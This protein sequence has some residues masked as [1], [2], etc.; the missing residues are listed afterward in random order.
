MRQLEAKILEINKVIGAALPL[1]NLHGLSELLEGSEKRRKEVGTELVVS[2][3]TDYPLSVYHV[4]DGQINFDNLQNRGKKKIYYPVAPLALICISKERKLEETI[5]E[6]IKS[7]PNITLK[8]SDGDK[9][10][11]WR[12][13]TGKE[14]PN[15]D[16][17]IFKIGYEF[18]YKTTE[19]D[20]C[21]QIQR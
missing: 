5:C 9:Y 20:H 11:I 2:F 16:Y 15:F 18:S 17:H 12:D 14:E 4:Q 3:D 13:E 8:Y 19:C 1:T 6:I 21:E 7:I 10:R